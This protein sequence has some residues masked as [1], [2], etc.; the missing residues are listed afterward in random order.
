MY[1]IGSISTTTAIKTT[2]PPPPPPPT[3]TTNA[4]DVTAIMITIALLY[5]KP[6]SVSLRYLPIV[7]PQLELISQFSSYLPLCN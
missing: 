6:S 7:I 1:T 3:T 2:P 4:T 5:Y